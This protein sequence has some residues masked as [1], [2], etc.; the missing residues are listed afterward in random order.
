MKF[1]WHEDKRLA[2]LRKHGIDFADCHKVFSGVTYTFEDN[3]EA[4]NEQRFITLGLLGT[5]VVCI[6]HTETTSRIRYISAR[7][8][9]KYEQKLYFENLPD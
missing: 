1:D 7:K 6:A 3:K 4:Y 8:A 5:H 9:T 2:N